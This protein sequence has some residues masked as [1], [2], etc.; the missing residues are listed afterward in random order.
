[1][2]CVYTARFDREANLSTLT[3][4]VSSPADIEVIGSINTDARF[5]L[6]ITMSDGIRADQLTGDHG[7]GG[8]VVRSYEPGKWVTLW[9][10]AGQVIVQSKQIQPLRF[11][12][13]VEAIGYPYQEGVQQCLHDGLYRLAVSTNTT[14]SASM[15]GANTLPLRLPSKFG[16]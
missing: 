14:A 1:M 12:D 13:R 7:S 6:P 4:W 8:G 3:L 2:R 5:A 10:A 11:G 15:I 16:I 9:D